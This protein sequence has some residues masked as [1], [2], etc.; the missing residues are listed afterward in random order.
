[1]ATTDS[2]C[3]F[4]MG[5]GGT[6]EAAVDFGSDR[7]AKH[8]DRVCSSCGAPATRQCT[9]TMGLVCGADLCDECEHETAEDGTNGRSNRH[10][11]KAEQRY[12]P[13]Y[14]RDDAWP[15]GPQSAVIE[16]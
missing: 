14:M 5:W 15:E 11:K 9:E 2:I 16:R 12:T 4:D 7:C 6:C 10:C 13:W 8:G 3:G 1:M